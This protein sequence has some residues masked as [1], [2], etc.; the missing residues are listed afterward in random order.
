MTA[1]RLH[2]TE[3]DIYGIY[4]SKEAKKQTRLQ[5]YRFGGLRKILINSTLNDCH[6]L[7]RLNCGSFF[8]SFHL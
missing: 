4:L 8:L 1:I 6:L 7:P 2:F 5:N 3:L